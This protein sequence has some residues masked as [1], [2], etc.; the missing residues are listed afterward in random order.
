MSRSSRGTTLEAPRYVPGVSAGDRT[1]HGTASP[2]RRVA[3]ADR[4]SPPVGNGPYG[5]SL[6]LELDVGSE[7]DIDSPTHE[8]R[9]E[10][11]GSFAVSLVADLAGAT[12]RFVDRRCRRGA[13]SSSAWRRCAKSRRTTMSE[14]SRVP[15]AMVLCAGLGTRLRP[16]TDEVA[17]PMVPVGD[18]PAVAH[19]LDRVRLAMA[20]HARVVANVHHRPDDLRSWAEG[21]G[22]A[23]SHEPELLGT[24]GGVARAREHLGQGDVLVWNGDILSELDPCELAMAHTTARA[25]RSNATLAVRARAAGEGNV[26]LDDRGR[27]VRLRT[28]SFGGE[29]RGGEFLGIHVIG[30]PLRERLPAQGC[31]VGDVYLPALA[32]G[33]H[34]HA[35]VTEARFVDVGSIAQ[36]LAANAA[37]LAS[38]GLRSWSHPSARVAAS[39]DGSVIGA[40]AVVDAPVIDGVVWPG[41]HVHDACK[42]AVV[43]PRT[44]THS[45][46]RR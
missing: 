23:I 8:A 1:A 21:E 28:Q 18:R 2:T 5:L 39:I 46:A 7:L 16:L 11:I 29:T 41:A 3:A 30:E 10:R 44:I 27:V 40:G 32:R 6:E 38:R 14:A 42:G 17:K 13:R 25:V 12:A 19:V 9:F 37:W 15:A 26:G 34:L 24:A 22:I 31:L 4:V 45:L 20:E 33:E 36:Y 35:F 43:T